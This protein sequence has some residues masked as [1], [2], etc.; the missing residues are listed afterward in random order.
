M[1]A[2]IRSGKNIM[3]AL[4]Y[5]E[6]K[7]KEGLA[8]CISAGNFVRPPGQLTFME[9]LQRFG[10][11]N[12]QN[13]NVKMNTI[14]ISLNF[15]PGDKLDK[16]KL[17][18]IAKEYMSKIGFGEQPYLVYQHY[19]AAHPHIHIVSNLVAKGGKRIDIHN[20]GRKESENARKEI[21][22]DF[23]LIMAEGRKAANAVYIKPLSP[24]KAKYGK[25]ETKRS[26]SNIV[27]YVTR[28]YK[29]TSLPELNAVL[30]QYNVIA[31]SGKE[32]TIMN[33]K[34]GLV[35]SILD[36]TGEKVGIPIKASSIN[37]KPTITNLEKLFKLNGALR[38][39]LRE[40][41]KDALD[42]FFT[43]EKRPSQSTFQ[44]WL[45]KRNIDV[46]FRKSQ[47]GRVYGLTFVDNQNKVVFNGSDLGKQYGA[48]AIMARL[49]EMPKSGPMV[50]SISRGGGPES[51][52]DFHTETTTG[53]S[54]P[55]PIKDLVS[56]EENLQGVDPALTRRRRR[57][58]RGKS[59]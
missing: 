2:K 40:R 29:Y 4:N 12:L 10:K 39:P 35:Y 3:G 54:L 58:R 43:H 11:L 45:A 59:L 55:K 53:T 31:D 47:D 1:V 8:E 46:V 16:I 37:G 13:S 26:I 42:L 14:H 33:M 41:T 30:R 57:K 19:D 23:N 7:V 27:G 56:A 5:N 17:T 51:T 18:E 32:G 34:K 15:D 24:D 44:G 49:A 9:K 28:N 21:E 36:R 48:K 20:L 50:K 25:S 22:R 6:N 52:T 38:T